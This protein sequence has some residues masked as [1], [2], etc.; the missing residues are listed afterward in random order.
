MTDCNPAS[1]PTWEQLD[2][3]CD[4]KHLSYRELVDSKFKN[5]EDDRYET[6]RRVDIL[7]KFREKAIWGVIAGLFITLFS[8][9]AAPYITKNGD[10]KNIQELATKVSII[11][12]KQAAFDSILNDVREDQIR[13]MKQEKK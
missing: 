3:H 1:H 9:W 12:D 10:S 2:K 8:I 4:E 13:R 6:K 7:E 5:S 11:V